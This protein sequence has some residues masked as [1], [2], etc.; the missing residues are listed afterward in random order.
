MEPGISREK[1]LG[2]TVEAVDVAVGNGNINPQDDGMVMEKVFEGLQPVLSLESTNAPYTIFTSRQ[3]IFIINIATFSGMVSPLASALYYP[4]LNVLVKDLKVSHSSINLTVTTYKILQGLSP[5]VL[6]S[7]SDA[8]GRRLI[9]IGGF[10]M[11]IGACIGLTVQRSFAALLVLR[12]L[13]S[14]GVSST[15]AVVVSVAAAT[16]AERGKYM[17][18]ISAGTS[19]GWISGPVLGG[20]LSHHFGWSSILW[21]L[22]S[23]A[24]VY[25]VVLIFWCPE[26]GIL[27]EMEVSSTK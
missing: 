2:A 20:V 5:V 8:V 3:V 16:T 22:A 11:F 7:L 4:A 1:P 25:V 18:F 14:A 27:L 9:F 13:Q 21:F 23:L 12:C 6:G 24:G 26:T 17:G 19:L 15:I 10:I